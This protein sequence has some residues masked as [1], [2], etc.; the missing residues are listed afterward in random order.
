VRLKNDI[1]NEL[2]VDMV[3]AEAVGGVLRLPASRENRMEKERE[4]Q[5]K[6]RKEKEKREREKS[7]EADRIG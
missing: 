6:Q 1:L 3:E 4:K 7:P 5:Q 2:F